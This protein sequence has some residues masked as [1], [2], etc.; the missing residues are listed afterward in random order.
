M[1]PLKAEHCMCSLGGGSDC[2]CCLQVS[3]AWSQVRVGIPSQAWTSGDHILFVPVTH[4]KGTP[5]EQ[6]LESGGPGKQDSPNLA[7]MC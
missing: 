7:Q 4:L 3:E 6:R 5:K 1:E 2:S